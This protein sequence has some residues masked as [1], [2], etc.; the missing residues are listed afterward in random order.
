MS[1]KLSP[2]AWPTP[3]ASRTAG[4][5]LAIL[6]PASVLVFMFLAIPQGWGGAPGWSAYFMILLACASV[7][8]FIR[9]AS[10]P[11]ER[12]GWLLLGLSHGILALSQFPEI[13]GWDQAWL[14]F[15]WL[16]RPTAGLLIGAGLL[17]WPLS[18]QGR[19][20]RGKQAL[21]GIIFAVALFFILWAVAWGDLFHQSHGPLAGKLLDLTFP[22]IYD[23][24]AAT[25]LYLSLRNP[26]SL[27]GPLGWVTL[28]VFLSF[29]QSL[30]WG[31][32]SLGGGYHPGHLLEGFSYLIP[33]MKLAAPFSPRPVGTARRASDVEDHSILGSLLPYLPFGPALVI[34]IHRLLAGPRPGDVLLVWLAMVMVI[35][36]LVRQFVSV[37]DLHLFSRELERRVLERTRDLENSQAALVRTQRMNLLATLGAGL[38]HDFNNMLGAVCNYSE[39]A[40]MEAEEGGADLPGHLAKI[41]GLS[42]KAADLASHLMEFGRNAERSPEAFDLGVKVED[43]GPMLRSLLPRSVS[44]SI[45]AWPEP[46]PFRGDA[47]QYE[48]ILV[49]LV[50]N[51]R[52]ALPGGGAIR[53]HVEPGPEPSSEAPWGRLVVADTGKGMAP[54]VMER[55]F[56]PFY[57]TKPT[58]EGTGLGLASVKSILDGCGGRIAVESEVGAGTVF[59]L[60]F[61]L[62]EI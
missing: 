60:L 47:R 41:H 52:D 6:G 15:Q 61:P 58:G 49:N 46:L 36:L 50:C 56:D 29:G 2:G 26:G 23:L 17:G 31:Y 62:A 16:M 25:C 22:A 20:E 48:Q 1:I 27:R 13:F 11:D 4:W 8:S 53:I 19:G 40:I 10:R 7:A 3:A 12:L 34:G 9:G 21:D 45:Q 30:L 44:L 38:A 5:A 51:A 55:I 43:L 14:P 54:E 28:G 42:R 57:T 37:R 33:V 24:L 35:L 32:L 18:T 59:T 39:M